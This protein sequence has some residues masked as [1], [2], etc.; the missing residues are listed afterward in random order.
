MFPS[1]DVKFRVELEEHA[2]TSLEVSMDEYFQEC[3]VFSQVAIDLG[4]ELEYL[5]FYYKSRLLDLARDTPR[6]VGMREGNIEE[7]AFN[8]PYEESEETEAASNGQSARHNANRGEEEVSTVAVADT[9]ASNCIV[10][11]TLLDVERLQA[12]HSRWRSRC[13]DILRDKASVGA[14]VKFRDYAG[15]EHLCKII[16]IEMG[17]E[18]EETLYTLQFVDQPTDQPRVDDVV[19][20]IDNITR[21]ASCAVCEMVENEVSIDGKTILCRLIHVVHVH[22]LTSFFLSWCCPVT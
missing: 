22:T 8:E 19:T 20:V 6:S 7:I 17:D 10:N 12:P 2:Y 1:D 9:N 21:L 18:D 13:V 5:R 11:D 4:E 3:V 14:H 15:K 16:G